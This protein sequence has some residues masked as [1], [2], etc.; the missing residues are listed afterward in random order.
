M[1]RNRHGLCIGRVSCACHG[2]SSCSLARHLPQNGINSSLAGAINDGSIFNA[3]GGL[4]HVSL[5]SPP[6]RV[7]SRGVGDPRAALCLRPLL[8]LQS[9]RGH[10]SLLVQKSERAPAPK[11]EGIG[12]SPLESA[13]AVSIND[14]SSQNAKKDDQIVP[15]RD[16][17]QC[18]NRAILPL[19]AANMSRNREPPRP[20]SSRA[21]GSSPRQIASSQDC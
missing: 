11:N 14:S 18:H 16:S 19:P 12:G 9:K 4:I 5:T 10:L 2:T 13:Q 3:P 6:P 8:L 7:Q 20:P 17:R 21:H 15:P 1:K